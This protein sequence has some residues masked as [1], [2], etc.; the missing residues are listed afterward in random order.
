MKPQK[1]PNK[2]NQYAL[3]TMVLITNV[4]CGYYKL[5][6]TVLTSKS[7]KRNVIIAKQFIIYFIKKL[8]PNITMKEIADFSNYT[9]HCNI[10]YTIKVV[11]S[12]ITFNNQYKNDFA[13][14]DKLLRVNDANINIGKDVSDLCYYVDLNNIVS[15]Q[16]NGN[17]AIVFS[18][19]TKDEINEALSIIPCLYDVKKPRKHLNT[20][21]YIIENNVNEK[22]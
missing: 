18:G 20:K 12:N 1:K 8:L 3:Q 22:D 7:R 9:T 6:T 10:L 15:V 5:P 2:T 13:E 19:F 14:I 11:E 16:T 17:K 4:V 21:L